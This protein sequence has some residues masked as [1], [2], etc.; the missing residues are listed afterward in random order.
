MCFCT[1]QSSYAQ[2]EPSKIIQEEESAEV[3]LEE[4]TDEF[5]DKFFEALKQKGIQN[6]DRAINLF[7][8]C[9][10]LDATNIVVDHE[11]AKAYLLDKKYISAQQYAIETL[12]A[13]P[14]NYWY[15]DTLI[16]ILEKQS[17]SIETVKANDIDMNRSMVPSLVFVLIEA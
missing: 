3:F 9:K 10:R 13:E 16:S 5:Q 12:V 1:L 4:Y 14:K 6:Y 8:D 2:E 17:N 15:L 7:L 11:L